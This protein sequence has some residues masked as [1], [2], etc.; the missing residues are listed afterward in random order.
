MYAYNRTKIERAKKLQQVRQVNSIYF[1]T[2]G[3]KFI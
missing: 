2:A 1:E 3:Y